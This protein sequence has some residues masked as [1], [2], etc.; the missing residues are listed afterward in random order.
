MCSLLHLFLLVMLATFLFLCKSW[1]IS[2]SWREMLSSDFCC[3]LPEQPWSLMN[4]SSKYVFLLKNQNLRALRTSSYLFLY[5]LPGVI[6]L[7][8][9][10]IILR[11]WWCSICWFIQH[12]PCWPF[13]HP[14]W[15]HIAW[16]CYPGL[17]VSL[18]SEATS[19]HHSDSSSPASESPL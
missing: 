7:P 2:R 19:K 13:Q 1:R 3:T 9:A 4:L 10:Q 16:P 11:C 17:P 6:Q 12:M 5:F 14:L 8:P 15:T 18:F